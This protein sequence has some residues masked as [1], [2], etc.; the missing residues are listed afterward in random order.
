MPFGEQIAGGSTTTHKF[1]GDERDGETGLDHTWF[2]QYSSQTAKWMTADP[3]RLPDG[4]AGLVAVSLDA[5][6]SLNRYSY[7]SNMP[8]SYFDPTG[9]GSCTAAERRDGDC[10]HQVNDA[11]GSDCEFWDP[12]CATTCIVNSFASSCGWTQSLVQQG[13][14][15]RCPNN[16]CFNQTFTTNNSGVSGFIPTFA[17]VYLASMSASGGCIGTTCILQASFFQ[18][19][20]DPWLTDTPVGID[21]WHSSAQ[22]PACGHFFTNATNFV[23]AS[24]AIVGIEAAPV[25]GVEGATVLGP[26]GPIFGTGEGGSGAGLNSGNRLRIGWSYLRSTGGHRFRI[27]GDWIRGHINLWSPSWWG[28]P[29]PGM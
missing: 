23:N 5:P 28:G 11:V 1:T 2:R 7:V 13:L 18:P 3:A 22:C 14:A 4:Q 26:E 12:S 6:E 16:D 24:T 10:G 17:S 20:G 19:V 15:A 27:A 8:L 21:I 29:P 9:L 25:V